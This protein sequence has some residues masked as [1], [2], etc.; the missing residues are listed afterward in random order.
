MCRFNQFH[1]L[2]LKREGGNKQATEQGLKEGM[3][4]AVHQTVLWPERHRRGTEAYSG[5]R[6]Q[7]RLGGGSTGEFLRVRIFG[8]N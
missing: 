3:T 2:L 6:R 5:V 4:V 8:R 1:L 7:R